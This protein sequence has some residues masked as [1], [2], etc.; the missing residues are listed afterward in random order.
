MAQDFLTPGQRRALAALCDTV[1]PSLPAPDGDDPHGFWARSASDLGVPA[2]LETVLRDLADDGTRRETLLLLRALAN[3][4]MAAPITGHFRGYADLPL[5]QREVVLRRWGRSPIPLLRKGFQGFKRLTPALFYSLTGEASKN[6]NWPAI[7]YPGPISPAPEGPRPLL[8]R[9]ITEDTEL[10]CDVVIAGSGAGGGVAAGELARAGHKVVVL[11]KGEY[12]AEPDFDGLELEGYRR[13][14]ENQ[15]NLATRD[16]GAVVL[17]GSNLGGGTTVNWNTSLRPPE[18]TLHE[19][20]R[21]HGLTGLAGPELQSAL[22]AVEVRCGVDTDESQINPQNAA[23]ARGA[24]SLGYHWS[25]IPRNVQGCG[26]YRTC[27]YCGFGCPRGAKQSTANTYLRDAARAGAEI[28]VNAEVRE[29]LV[30]GG[31]AVGVRARAGP[32][33]V[34]VK[35]KTV[36]VAAGGIHTP[37]VLVRSGLSGP[38]VGRRLYFHPTTGILGEFDDVIEMWSG[39]P[40][41]VVVDHFAN[42]DGKGYGFWLETPPPHPGLLSSA[43]AWH[44]GREHK[45]MM[46]RYPRLAAFIVLVRERVGGRLTV[47]RKGRPVMHY[48]LSQEDQPH[49]LRGIEEAFRIHHA[50]G[51]REIAGPH[52]SLEPYRGGS[53]E[54]Y[55]KGL[56]RAGFRPNT[57]ALF[58]AHQ[59]G[60]CPMGGSASRSVVD[61]HGEHWDVKNLFVADGSVFPTALG[62]NPMLTIMALAHRTAGYVKSRL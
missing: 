54:G 1:V 45:E 44:S 14:Y 57:Y 7:G 59:M 31:R 8:P 16:L 2:Q 55:L 22:E 23:L 61:P 11:E 38:N 56:A 34:T 24:E 60:T 6:P 28:V 58:S 9:R 42:W 33:Q 53:L 12:Y 20:E 5:E 62:V 51:A 46:S 47:D 25:R 41:S 50:A 3:P 36:V 27:G 35:A 32:S 43:L 49:M 4:A 39:V 26:D 21:E 37:A 48:R 29:V 40:Q 30:K 13:L 52:S 17:A 15:A 19:W 10:D 18:Y